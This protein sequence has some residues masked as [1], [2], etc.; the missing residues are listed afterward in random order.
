MLNI[1]TDRE[2]SSNNFFLA[3]NL[4]YGITTNADIKRTKI[5]FYHI[6]HICRL[7]E[8]KKD[9]SDF[10]VICTIRE[11]RNTL[12]SGMEHCR[13]YN[14]NIYNAHFLYQLKRIFEESEPNIAIYKKS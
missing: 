8:F 13:K 14:I 2:L 9:F 1:L 6:H 12:V 10:G 7:K 4:A 11:P 5:I 3:V